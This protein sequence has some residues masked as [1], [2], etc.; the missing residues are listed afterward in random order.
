MQAPRSSHRNLV[1]RKELS[2]LAPPSLLI[3]PLP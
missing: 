1:K 2:I 3:L